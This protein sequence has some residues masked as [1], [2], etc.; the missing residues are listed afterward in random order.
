MT[1][2]KRTF[3]DAGVLIA[4]ARGDPNVAS[5][6]MKVLDDPHREFA[7]SIFVKLEVLPKAIYNQKRAEASFYTEF[8]AGVRFWADNFDD[9]TRE[10]YR[11]ACSLGLNA[12]DSLHVTAAASVQAEE[13]VTTEKPGKPIHRSRCIRV[14]S[15]QPVKEPT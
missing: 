7:S 1:R 8:F 10:A 15:I 11:R 3:V 6:A 5:E 12:M 9:I 4:A 14:V 13:L 2:V